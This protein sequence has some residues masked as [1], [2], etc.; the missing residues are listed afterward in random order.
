MSQN[1]YDRIIIGD[2]ILYKCPVIR[3]V[4]KDKEQIRR[5]SKETDKEK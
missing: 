5:V 3:L 1:S 2:G 4:E